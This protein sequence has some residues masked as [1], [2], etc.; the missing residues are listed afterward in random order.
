MTPD[1]LATLKAILEMGWPAI[2]TV[3]FY[4]LA[5]QYM[6]SVES[7]ISYLRNQVSTLEKELIEVKRQLLASHLSSDS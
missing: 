1:T 4:L 5:R 2:V 7:E 6:A 3:A